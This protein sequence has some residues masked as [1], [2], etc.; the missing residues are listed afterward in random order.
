MS[1]LASGIFGGTP[2]TTTPIAGPWLSPQVVK[3][4]SVPNVLPAMTARLDDRNVRGVGAFHADDVITAIDVVHLARDPGRQLAQQINPGAAD[5]LD[6]D[7][8]LQW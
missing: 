1:G 2:S 3:R 5:I 7:V 4:N 8:A 6:R